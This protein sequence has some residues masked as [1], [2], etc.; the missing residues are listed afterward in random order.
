MGSA[1]SHDSFAHRR[2]CHCGTQ[3]PGADERAPPGQ[4]E[5]EEARQQH[6]A[7]AGANTRLFEEAQTRNTQLRAALES[8]QQQATSSASL[9]ARPPTSNPSSTPLFG[10]PSASS[11][12]TQRRS[13]PLLARKFISELLQRLMRLE[14]MLSRKF[15]LVPWQ[16]SPS[17]QALVVISSRV[18]Y[19]IRRQISASHPQLEKRRA[20]EVSGAFSACRWCAEGRRLGRSLSHAVMLVHSLTMRLHL[21]RPSP[22]RP[23]SPLRTRGC[24]RQSRLEQERSRSSRRNS[25]DL[26]NIRPRSVRC[27][28]SSLV[29]P[30][31]CSRSSTL[32]PQAVSTYFGRTRR[33]SLGLPGTNYGSRHSRQSARRRTEY[34]RMCFP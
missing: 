16:V 21:S 6:A 18:S 29:R 4:G 31:S 30:M 24:S 32:L 2:S 13:R 17:W 19:P 26:W 20:C 9:A 8:K 11:M 14:T 3:D 27:S 28:A 23:S 25:R 12:A 5:L 33:E 22:T 34:C 1:C 10:M 15:V 7:T